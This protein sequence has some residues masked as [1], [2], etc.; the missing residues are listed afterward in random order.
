[1]STRDELEQRAIRELAVENFDAAI[2]DLQSIAYLGYPPPT[3]RI[4]A[5]LNGISNVRLWE[6]IP[7]QVNTNGPHGGGCDITY[8]MGIWR[9]NATVNE[10]QFDYVIKVR[11]DRDGRFGVLRHHA[12]RGIVS[13]IVNKVAPH[14]TV[15]IA[16]RIGIIGKSRS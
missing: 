10:R 8:P 14:A 3:A 5:A 15:S 4:N 16:K 9:E 6:G 2:R 13:L 1:M 12:A 11:W 7:S